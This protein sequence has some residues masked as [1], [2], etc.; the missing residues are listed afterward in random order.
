MRPSDVLG[1]RLMFTGASWPITSTASLAISVKPTSYLLTRGSLGIVRP[2]V[3]LHNDPILNFTRLIHEVDFGGECGDLAHSTYSLESSSAPG[4]LCISCPHW[5]G[6]HG[7]DF[8]VVDFPASDVTIEPDGLG[9][10]T[11]YKSTWHITPRGI[12][13]SSARPGIPSHACHMYVRNRETCPEFRPTSPAYHVH[14]PNQTVKL[15]FD[16]RLPD[17]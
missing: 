10:R 6:L 14:T 3:V 2:S 1:T 13:S 17:E 7:G 5:P 8:V 15:E 12:R 4:S 9:V 11:S 16:G